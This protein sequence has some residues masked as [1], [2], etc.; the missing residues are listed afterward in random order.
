[1]DKLQIYYQ[2]PQDN[3]DHLKSLTLSFYDFDETAGTYKK[4]IV[5][6]QDGSKYKIK[7]VL[8]N[9]EEIRKLIDSVDFAKYTATD[10]NPGDPYYFIKKGDL[11]F[12][13]GNASSIKALLDAVNFDEILAY[14]L[15]LYK[16]CD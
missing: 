14:D 1:M 2:P 3:P 12:A 4:K 11:S 9:L 15:S 10:V 6:E 7:D 8:T 5:L 13:T 16:K